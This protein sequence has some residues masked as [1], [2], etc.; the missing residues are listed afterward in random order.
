MAKTWFGEIPADRAARWA[1]VRGFAASWQLPVGR[2]ADAAAIAAAEAR[3][4]C[5]LPAALVEVY[6]T[7]GADPDV[8][9]GQDAWMP[10]DRLKLEDGHLVVRRENQACERWGVAPDADDDPPVVELDEGRVAE[11]TLSAFAIKVL[12]YERGFSGW[13]GVHGEM[14]DGWVE[15]VDARLRR[16]P[17]SEVYWACTPLRI[18]EGP[19]VVLWA[20]DAWVFGGLRDAAALARVADLVEGLETDLPDEEAE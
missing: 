16:V 11:D 10:L 2:P 15:R 13:A 12:L 9:S 17:V 8:L 14:P 6:Q 18:W 1:A 3:L 7:L 4:G 5:R 19:G 20:S